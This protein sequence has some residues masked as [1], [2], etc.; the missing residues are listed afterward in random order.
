MVT[1][2]QFLADMEDL[3]TLQVGGTALEPLVNMLGA[4]EEDTADPWFCPKLDSLALRG[5]R[6]HGDGA[7]K[8]VQMIE[9]RN[10]DGGNAAAGVV[11]GGGGGGVPVKLRHL[12]LI[13]CG[14]ESDVVSWLDGRIEDVMCV[15]TYDV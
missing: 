1:S 6:A 13:D 5:C 11:A 15:E 3:Q 12:E 9:A 8:L 4:P 10:P 7:A 2:W 14:L